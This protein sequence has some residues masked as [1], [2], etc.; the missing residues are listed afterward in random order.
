ML[1]DNTVIVYVTEVARAWDH[2][3]R[4]MPLIVFGA[5]NTKVKGGT[6][7]KV[8]GGPLGNQAGGSSGNRPFNDFWLALLQ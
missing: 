1:I 6:F 3:Q 8:T 4:N 5:K 2:D 7:L